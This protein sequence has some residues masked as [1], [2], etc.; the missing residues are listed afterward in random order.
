MPRA[1]EA[2]DYDFVEEENTS[3][4]QED[5][6]GKPNKKTWSRSRQ[7]MSGIMRKHVYKQVSNGLPYLPFPRIP[8]EKATLKYV[9]HGSSKINTEAKK[10]SIEM[11][12]SICYRREYKRI[13]DRL[14][15]IERMV[16]AAHPRRT[17][18][19][20]KTLV[21]HCQLRWVDENY[22]ITKKKIDTIT[23]TMLNTLKVFQKKI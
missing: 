21:T 23:K 8:M 15:T 17:E 13:T 9:K 14:N 11:H 16:L 12:V 20:K 18:K 1:K 3:I 10:N 19:V 6:R 2:T 22:T 4:P 7:I 5:E